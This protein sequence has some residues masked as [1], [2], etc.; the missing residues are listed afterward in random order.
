MDKI[1]NPDGTEKTIEATDLSPRQ[2][3]LSEVGQK[4]L[5]ARE[6]R[7]EQLSAVIRKL[8]LRES[9]LKALE[10]GN[11]DYLPDDVYA[12]G[13]LRQYSNY[14]ELDLKDEIQRIKNDEYI[15]TRPLTFPDPPVAPSHKWAWIAGTAFIILFITFNVFN[16][17]TVRNILTSPEPTLQEVEQVAADTTLESESNSA[18]P[19]QQASSEVENA[20]A[21]NSPL[22]EQPQAETNSEHVAAEPALPADNVSTSTENQPLINS[23]QPSAVEKSSATL[24]TT[25]PQAIINL[26][27][28]PAVESEETVKSAGGEPETH[29]FRFEAVTESVWLQVFLPGK[30]EN[31]KGKLLKEVLLQKGK[32]IS[33]NKAVDSLWI[34]CGN[35]AAMRIKVDGQIKADTGSLGDV[36]KVLRNYHFRIN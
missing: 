36:G 2:K 20:D 12:L 25:T 5:L 1:N 10:E 3:L 23:P 31:A 14:L 4:L 35:P 16:Q 18:L 29:Q 30:T 19:A 26:T 7:D 13:F 15:L 34:T 17:D 28:K 21:N 6:A 9:N 32:H 27:A 22:P 8:K 33:I 11:W 24:A